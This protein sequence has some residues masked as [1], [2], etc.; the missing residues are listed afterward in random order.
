M[1]PRAPQTRLAT[2]VPPSKPQ[3]G[4]CAFG[5]VLPPAPARCPTCESAALR[6]S[7]L[8]GQVR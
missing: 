6:L 1:P 2:L 4:R 8:L 3:A 7:V 5:H